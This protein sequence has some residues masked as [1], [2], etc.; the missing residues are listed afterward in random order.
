MFILKIDKEER[1]RLSSV[2]AKVLTEWA[3]HK[4]NHSIVLTGP[5]IA[6]LSQVLEALIKL[7]IDE[8]KAPPNPN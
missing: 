2:R 3:L 1:A 6:T 7:P 8:E 5:E 4:F